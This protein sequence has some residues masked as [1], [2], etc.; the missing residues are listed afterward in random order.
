[1]IYL[2]ENRKIFPPAYIYK[3]G[4]GFGGRADSF[5]EPTNGYRHWSWY[6]YGE[7]ATSNDANAR[8]AGEAFRCP[9]IPNGGL[10]PSNPSP[11]D[12]DEGQVNDPDT[13]PGIIDDQVDRC[14]YTVNE[15][16][17]PR[18][19]WGPNIRPYRGNIFYR[20]VNAGKIKNGSEIVLATEFWADWRLVSDPSNPDLSKSHR[21]VSGYLPI[22][23]NALDL[24]STVAIPTGTR[25]THTRVLSVT[26][27]LVN[28]AD[29]KNTL[30]FIGR[31]HGR[32]GRADRDERTTNFLYVDG[33]VENK[34]IEQTI[35]PQFQ[36]GPRDTI[37]SLPNSVVQQ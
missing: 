26:N 7:T 9:S 4:A 16:I 18:N 5:P 1:A 21:P 32:R 15:A 2:A 31:N 24:T 34:T 23:G 20:Y 33:H 17:M 19:K 14:A 30:D 13:L 37:W 10:T 22:G 35:E 6:I 12:R 3:T 28:S 36:W 27:P 8:P 25:T 11:K 29:V